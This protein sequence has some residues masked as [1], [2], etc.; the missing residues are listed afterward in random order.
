M[1][2]PKYNS[3]INVNNNNVYIDLINVNSNNS[4]LKI[5]FNENIAKEIANLKD[6]KISSTYTDKQWERLIELT[7]ADQNTALIVA[8][9]KCPYF[10][11]HYF[12]NLRHHMEN[13]LQNL[14]MLGEQV[15]DDIINEYVTYGLDEDEE[16]CDKIA[17]F[18]DLYSKKVVDFFA[19]ELPLDILNKIDFK[20]F[21][22]TETP[23]VIKYIDDIIENKDN[24]FE[25]VV[26]ESFTSA[27]LDNP[28][29]PDKIKNASFNIAF[30]PNDVY[31]HTTYVVE[32]M[33]E[34]YADSIFELNLNDNVQKYY[35]KRSSEG[36]GNFVSRGLL[37]VSCELDFINRYLS[38]PTDTGLKTLIN[39]LLHTKNS[40]TIECAVKNI[41]I[42]T[43]SNVFSE[44]ECVNNEA[45]KELLKKQSPESLKQTFINSVF[46]YSY[47]DDVIEQFLN[48]NN[49]YID[50]AIMLS[51]QNQ[52]IKNKILSDANNTPL[53][54]FKI[55]NSLK[56]N[57]S[58]HLDAQKIIPVF[59]A[60][61]MLHKDDDI[62]EGV[63][64]YGEENNIPGYIEREC[65]KNNISK[66]NSN[67]W[68]HLN[69]KEYEEF[70]KIIINSGKETENFK[71]A[72]NQ[73]IKKLE[74]AYNESKLIDKYPK[75]FKP[76]VPKNEKIFNTVYGYTDVNELA[77]LSDE[78]IKDFF[79][80][81]KQYGNYETLSEIKYNLT[82]LQIN[83][84][85]EDDVSFVIY[86]LSDFYNGLLDLI[87]EKSERTNS[88]F[89][90][91]A[92]R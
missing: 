54:K 63:Y 82:H 80:D 81:V 4:Y 13:D 55:L 43:V 40:K 30:N 71:N 90:M 19:T 60:E 23:D 68:F 73:T 44:C 45:M 89:V 18:I 88:D 38:N 6:E 79:E 61:I 42:S 66:M 35:I 37:P 92:E 21:A 41:N 91:N 64:I 77:K 69:D 29:I 47:E 31:N 74:E 85:T 12:F 28:N 1:V 62:F 65:L 48:L 11:S 39:V 22:L 67:K 9:V 16:F 52:N 72:I 75:I 86:K 49:K 24:E 15:P 76:T 58:H 87:E 84:S 33:Y 53:E 57:L 32:K 26:N 17:V 56:Q 78:K 36:I 46:N 14:L 70:K 34:M 7:T 3:L 2:N 10:P 8:L 59:I 83:I 5:N 20:P 27:I 51:P 25:D 50:I